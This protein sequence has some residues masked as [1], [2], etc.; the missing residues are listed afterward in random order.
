MVVIDSS[1][2]GRVCALPGRFAA[3]V[4]KVCR[5]SDE[6]LYPSKLLSYKVSQEFLTLFVVLHGARVLPESIAVGRTFCH[7]A[8]PRKRRPSSHIFGRDKPLY[9]A[10]RGKT[11]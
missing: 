1:V 6:R 9:L 11:F 2:P 3:L 5:R 8:L 10:P 7:K 4:T